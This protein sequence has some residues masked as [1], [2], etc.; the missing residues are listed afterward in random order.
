MYGYHGR[1]L[2]VDL[3]NESIERIP[4]NESMLRECVGGTGLGTRLLLSLTGTDHLERKPAR[5]MH[6]LQMH[7]Y[8]SCLAR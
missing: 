6:W 3:T 1:L 8:C 5:T 7:H 2:H 4:I